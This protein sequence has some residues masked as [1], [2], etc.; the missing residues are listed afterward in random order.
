MTAPIYAT[1]A[2]YRDWLDDQ[3]VDV[4]DALFARASEII[5]EALIGAVYAVDTVTQKPTDTAELE[6]VRDATCAQVQWLLANGDTTGTGSDAT[7]KTVSIGSVSLGERTNAVASSVTTV[8]GVPLA[9]GVVR[10]LRVAGLLPAS[11]MTCG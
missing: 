2:E 11:V 6:A 10:V 7:Y 1:L 8:S 9:P 3:T 4:S 5:D